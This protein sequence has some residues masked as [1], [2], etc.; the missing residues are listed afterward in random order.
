MQGAQNKWDRDPLQYACKAYCTARQELSIL[1]NLQH[2]NIV[3]LIGVCT[4]PLAL[5]LDLAPGGA[6]DQTLK[7]YR[8]SGA[9]FDA[10]MLQAIILQVRFEYIHL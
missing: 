3:P 7:L 5:I 1:S 4:K 9:K 6:L 2:I 8:R 10:F